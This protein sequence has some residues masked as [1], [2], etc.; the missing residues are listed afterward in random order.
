MNIS[1]TPAG[2]P[3]VPA[4]MNRSRWHLRANAPAIAWLL[5]L[6]VVVLF[7]RNIPVSG[8]LMVHLLLL[9]A[10]TNSIL[11]WS[12]HFAQ[13]LLRG[14]NP[15]SRGMVTRLVLLNAAVVAVVVSMVA[16]IWVLTL[17]GSIVVGAVVAAHAVVLGLRARTSLPSRF[18]PTVWYYVAACLLL[19]V[20]AGVGAALAAGLPEELHAR[21]L[22]VHM[23]V[24][25]LGFVGITVLGTLMTLLPTMLHTRVAD[26]AE[27]VARHGAVP[28]LAGV[29]LT[30][31]GAS[32]GTM[33][34]C[35]VGLLVYLGAIVYI[36]IPLVKVVRAKP[37]V[38][39][40]PLSAV[41]ALVWLVVSI[42]WLVLLTMT[43]GG[44]DGL[45]RGLV[46]VAPVLAAGF[47]AQVLGAALT[48]LAPVVLGG[49]PAM[50]KHRVAILDKV[51]VF[52]V[53][54]TNFAL[55]VSLLPVPSLVKVGTSFLV[56]V[57]LAW[58]LPLLALALFKKPS[59][60]REDAGIGGAGIAAGAAFDL[61]PGRRWGMAATGMAV[62]V[63]VMV[64]GVIADPTTLPGL[65]QAAAQSTV[66]ATGVTTT[67][68]ITMKDM[69]FHPD[70]VEVP[71]GN[72]LVINVVNQDS[73]VHDLVTAAGA[74]SGRLYPGEKAT[75]DAGVIGAGMDGWCSIAGHKQQG[76]VFSIAVTGGPIAAPSASA[77]PGG[78]MAGMD[79]SGAG[80][81]ATGPSAASLLDFMKKAPADFTAHDPVIPALPQGNVHKVAMKVTE[82]KQDVAVGVN[83]TLWTFNGTAPGPTLRGK[84]GDK[85]IITLTNDGSLGHSIDLHA[86]ALAP[87]QP[88][89]T[90]NPGETLTYSFTATRA[91]IWM[92]HC[93]TMP[94]S[95]HIANGMFGA[96]II[97]PPGLP[98]VDKEYVLIQSEL[99]LGPQGG[100]ADLA[101]IQAE[102]PDAVV[103]NGYANQYDFRPL[104]AKVGEKVRV[105][106]L[107][108]GPNKATSF[109]IVGG[110]LSTVWS[111]GRYLL[112]G[113]DPS[114]GSQALALAPAQ[115]GFVELTFPEAGNYPF[116]SH[117]MVDAE[118]GAHGIFA[119]SQ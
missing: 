28:L 26:G 48:Y 94:M 39:F 46:T 89:R 54:L 104:T 60:P 109:H 112:D 84:V 51:G 87:D 33:F 42:V 1:L 23:S 45:H 76:M 82:Q 77:T 7:H 98:S 57:G 62:V 115:G 9:G 2:K 4:P 47:A 111:E 81:S 5:A 15:G 66:Q 67:V 64:A 86:G 90:I 103:F 27:T 6:V 55:L 37:A 16:N 63:L 18:G 10:V 53:V 119:I 96:V 70:K 78:G 95:L 88:M 35:T 118:R 85:F 69:R 8:W 65:N 100:V 36:C 21:L 101:K 74:E 59:G 72:K 43:A 25:V 68:D 58:I 97:D 114:A 22:L 93:S 56:L 29:L 24:N 79:H 113:S 105:W 75:V 14:P 73:M 44:W 108:A 52:R 50:L 99:Y 3:A 106:V 110:Q 19:P 102:K 107:D 41:A 17:F 30:A 12:W 117:Y 91:G 11:V 71:L 34:L 61:A 83:Q 38:T 31:I 92:Y 49:G 80:S 116:V 20:G 40:A 32:A 13:A